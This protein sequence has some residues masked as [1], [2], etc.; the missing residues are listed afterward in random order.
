MTS[1]TLH[2]FGSYPDI[3]RAEAV[4]TTY[5]RASV[6]RE[7]IAAGA[8]VAQQSDGKV[9]WVADSIPVTLQHP[10][11]A[12]PTWESMIDEVAA[13]LG[14]D[15]WPDLGLVL[16]DLPKSGWFWGGHYWPTGV[17][18]IMTYPRST[19]VLHEFGHML[20]C[21]HSIGSLA[22]SED[23]RQVVRTDPRDFRDIDWGDVMCSVD[24]N[25]GDPTRGGYGADHRLTMGWLNEADI[26]TVQS[27]A[28]IALADTNLRT[29]PRA[30]RV[31]LPDGHYYM[32]E[33]AFE[34]YPYP[35]VNHQ[36]RTPTT[37]QADMMR[38]DWPPGQ[39]FYDPFRRLLLQ[40]DG[41][42]LTVT[43]DSDGPPPPPIPPA[44]TPLAVQ[45]ISPF[46]GDTVRGRVQLTA[47]ASAPASF[48]WTADGKPTRSTWNAKK[49][50]HVIGVAAT[51][52]AG[53][54][55]TAAIRV[56]GR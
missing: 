15:R 27:A 44:V 48:A 38:I 18:V 55:A 37:G 12:Y 21:R 28:R 7:L 24:G 17:P 5:D 25:I 35:R 46:D 30:A 50:A 11:G 51:D 2:I 26:L 22:P 20:G 52:Q 56:T 23:Y 10:Y 13:Q 47:A 31:M 40:D 36:V 3:G 49:G 14:A 4:V 41:V 42:N 16:L 54:I 9:Q 19:Q 45:I 32:V 53:R 1:R 8:V 6:L 33:R 43:Y 29:W 39:D 34:W